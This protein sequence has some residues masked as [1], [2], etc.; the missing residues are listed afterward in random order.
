MD[1]L[2]DNLVEDSTNTD[3]DGGVD[4]NVLNDYNI[5][6]IKQFDFEKLG[7]EGLFNPMSLE[8]LQSYPLDDFIIQNGSPFPDYNVKRGI[9]AEGCTYQIELYVWDWAYISRQ[10]GHAYPMRMLQDLCHPLFFRASG[11]G[12]YDDYPTHEGRVQIYKM[13]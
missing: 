1:F 9:S 4:D 7:S 12:L 13:R 10:S 3:K 5:L 8:E 2:W 6:R 11:T